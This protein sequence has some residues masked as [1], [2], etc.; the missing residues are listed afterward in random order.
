[1]HLN[2]APV[3]QEFNKFNMQHEPFE[4]GQKHTETCPPLV[5]LYRGLILYIWVKSRGTILS[6]MLEE[7]GGVLI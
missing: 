5:S 1:M 2:V 7:E 4:H 3:C 6:G